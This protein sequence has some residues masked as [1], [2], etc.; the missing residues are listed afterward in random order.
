M[1]S[2]VHAY[3]ARPVDCATP[4]VTQ[5][6]SMLSLAP[7][8]LGLSSDPGTLPPLA[9]YLRPS[10]P[11]PIS[12]KIIIAHAGGDIPAPICRFPSLRSFHFHSWP[13]NGEYRRLNLV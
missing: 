1:V 10:C 9:V 11:M 5:N 13:Q 4:L 12:G 7:T 2:R 6:A 3:L 8:G